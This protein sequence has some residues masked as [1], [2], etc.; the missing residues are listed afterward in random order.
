MCEETYREWSCGHTKEL[1]KETCKDDC[2]TWTEV[3]HE[4]YSYV[5]LKCYIATPPDFLKITE[6]DLAPKV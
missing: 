2:G 5:C 1:S 4:K 3:C 6:E